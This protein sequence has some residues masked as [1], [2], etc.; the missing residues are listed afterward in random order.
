MM[1]RRVLGL[2]AFGTALAVAPSLTGQE[3]RAA[4]SARWWSPGER[5]HSG[6]HRGLRQPVRN[7][8]DPEHVRPARDEGHPFFEPIGTNGRACVTCHQPADGMSLSVRSIR[9]RWGATG[10][11]DPLFAAVDGMNCPNLPPDD[12][13]SH[14]LLLERGLF[15]VALPWPPQR[16]DGTPI[17]PEFTIEVVRD[18]SG[19]NTDPRLRAEQREPD[20][21]GVPPSAP[22]GEH[23]VHDAPELRRRPVHRQ[24]RHAGGDAIR[25]RASRRA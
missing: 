24:E 17:D 7:A 5:P 4:S 13:A 1:S 23:E 14:S 6:V 15:R 10:G 21:L 20:D 25:R 18:P 22:G 9:E 11:K 16:A 12:P 8:V 3:P 19:C 2:L